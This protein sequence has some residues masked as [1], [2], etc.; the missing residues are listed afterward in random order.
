[1]RIRLA[2]ILFGLVALTTACAQSDAG[3]TTS[4]KSQLA[5]DDLVKARNIDVDTNNRVVTLTGSV[6]SEKEETKALE[7]VRA[8]RGVVDVVDNLSV[9]AVA[10]PSAAPTTG[11][12]GAT[13]GILERPNIDPGLT[14]GVKM[15][16][17]ADPTVSGLE[18]DVDTR[19]RI[20]TLTGTVS[21]QVEKERALKI[22]R[23]VESV[24]H[25]EDKLTVSRQPR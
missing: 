9:A 4:V 1:M 24:A 11:R 23:G 16:L 6:Q 22:A 19:D 20:V 14:A 5:A 8:T 12:Y 7:I 10:E 13:P 18:I 25:V 21:S 17:L 3:I 15:K 2:A